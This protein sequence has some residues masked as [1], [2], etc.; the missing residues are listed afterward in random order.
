M[1]PP[2]FN[3]LNSF[4]QFCVPAKHDNPLIH[5]FL[6]DQ[7]ALEKFLFKKYEQYQGKCSPYSIFLSFREQT[8]PLLEISD[9]ILHPDCLTVLNSIERDLFAQYIPNNKQITSNGRVK[10]LFYPT[11]KWCPHCKQILPSDSFHPN[12]R[13]V[14]GMKKYCIKCCISLSDISHARQLADGIKTIQPETPPSDL[15]ALEDLH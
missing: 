10:P 15:D 5:L 1:K 8:I 3:F 9:P 14:D 13:S 6:F 12:Y 7:V 11:K 4:N 2:K